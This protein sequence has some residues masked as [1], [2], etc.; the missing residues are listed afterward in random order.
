MEDYEMVDG[1]LS[2][3]IRKALLFY[4][5]KNLRLDVPDVE[6]NP[7]ATPLKILNYEDFKIAMSHG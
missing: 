1:K 7:A 4:F 6:G 2:I 5:E 3:P